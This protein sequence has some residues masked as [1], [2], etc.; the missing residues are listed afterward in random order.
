MAEDQEHG[1]DNEMEMRDTSYKVANIISEIEHT[2]GRQPE[3]Y[4]VKLL[5]DALFEISSKR[6]Q[7]TIITKQEL[8]K[9]KRWYQLPH[10]IVDMVRVEIK[11]T[12]N[13][14]VMIPKLSDPHR[15][16]KE[17]VE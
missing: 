15:L 9:D 8:T 6:Q 17:D 5:N 1:F 12:N 7:H 4:I 14:Y 3:Q 13:R 16:L 10:N 11:D 2:F